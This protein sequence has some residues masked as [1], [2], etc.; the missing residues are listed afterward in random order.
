MTAHAQ[1]MPERR[2]VCPGLAAP[3][4]TGDGLL[5]R[6]APAGTM[7]LAAFKHFCAAARTHGN[8]IVEVSARGSI[9]VRGLS[10]VSAR[11][12]AAAIAALEIA[13]DDTV[14]ILC[15]PLAGIA[16]EEIFDVTP[17]ARELRR[18]LAKRSAA[19]KLN[20]KISVAI[21]GG[22]RLNLA[23][24]PADIRLTAKAANGA[25]QLRVAVG[26]DDARAVALGSV[27]PEHGVEAACRL[28]G[29]LAR[30]GRHARAHDIVAAG[31][32]AVFRSALSSSPAL[33]HAPAFTDG[34]GDTQDRGKSHRDGQ[35]I[36]LH[37]LRDGS[38]AC[39]LGLA[40][41]YADAGALERLADA[42]ATAGARGLRAA[43]GRTLLTIGLSEQR[44]PGF[45]AAAKQLGFITRADDPRLH[46]LACAGAPLCAS[47]YIAARAMAPAVAAAAAPHL[48]GDVAVHISGCAKG[49]ARP[50]AATLTVVGTAGDCALVANGSA[51]DA[52]FAAA[53]A[54]ELPVAIERYLREREAANV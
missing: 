29:V 16:A 18:T 36:A 44:A 24:V 41:G 51:R 14:P 13:A 1:R 12:F 42:A 50:A 31:G 2:G 34:D 17:L 48:T 19:L 23:R 9:Q 52:P 32:V 10:A 4:Q 8:G 37:R 11:P 6:F 49:C 39:G 46:V 38:F 26:G 45:V 35:P 22:A 54:N 28:L 53:P 40:F 27:A 20:A 25:T 3:M 15:N 5:A 21:D 30:R 33:L 43:P 47:A 7:T